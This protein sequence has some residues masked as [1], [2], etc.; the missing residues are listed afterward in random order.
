MPCTAVTRHID[1]PMPCRRTEVPFK[2]QRIDLLLCSEAQ[3]SVILDA[4]PIMPCTAVTRHIDI[5]MPCRRT[6]VPFKIQ[7]IDLLLCSEAQVQWRHYPCFWIF[8]AAYGTVGCIG[9]F[10]W[11]INK[12]ICLDDIVPICIITVCDVLRH[13]P[14]FWIFIAAYGTVGC[15]GRFPWVINKIICL[16]DIV[17]ICII[18]VCDVL[19]KI[20]TLRNKPLLC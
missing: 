17:P 13:Y 16:D 9:R 18:T 7:R 19:I 10:P 20:V 12:I 5:P 2:I 1:I 15:I 4:H 14:C 6:E 11:V 8:I 3:K